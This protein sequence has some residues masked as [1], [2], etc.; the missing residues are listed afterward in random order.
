[1]KL[2]IC[3]KFQ[4]NRMNC[5]ESRRGGGGPIDPPPPS[6]LRV[7]IFSRRLLGLYSFLSYPQ[8]DMEEIYIQIE[9]EIY[10]EAEP[11]VIREEKEWTDGI[12]RRF[13]QTELLMKQWVEEFNQLSLK[14][15]HIEKEFVNL[16]LKLRN[17]FGKKCDHFCSFCCCCY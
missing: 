12:Y 3:T 11:S 7:T 10:G 14:N 17:W 1:M 6:R 4:V 13:T 9:R 16:I 8:S 5:V 2:V 15:E